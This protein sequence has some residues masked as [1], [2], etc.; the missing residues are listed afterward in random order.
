VWPN[1]PNISTSKLSARSGPSRYRVALPGS[2]RETGNPPDRCHG[3]RPLR[4]GSPTSFTRWHRPSRLSTGRRRDARPPFV[5]CRALRR[6]SR[7][8]PSSF[9]RP[10][11]RPLTGKRRDAPPFAP[12]HGRRPQSRGLPSSF[13]LR[14]SST[15][16]SKAS[17]SPFVGFLGPQS[18]TAPSSSRVSRIRSGAWTGSRSTA[19]SAGRWRRASSSPRLVIPTSASSTGSPRKSPRPLGRWPA[20]GSRGSS[21]IRC[22]PRRHSIQRDSPGNPKTATRDAL[23]RSRARARVAWSRPRSGA[24]SAARLGP[25][26]ASR[27]SSASAA[28]CGRPLVRRPVPRPCSGSAWRLP[29]RPSRAITLGVILEAGQTPPGPIARQSRRRATTSARWIRRHGRT[30]R[31]T[32]RPATTSAR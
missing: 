10:R 17:P 18:R 26:T 16:G 20:R 1:R 30:R 13:F 11:F 21:S 27:S 23:A 14:H 9:S 24:S 12:C 5:H 19:T 7:G 4:R 8:L 31:Q 6:L 32:P 25:Q 2:R 29:F 22:H 28:R 3:R 15:G